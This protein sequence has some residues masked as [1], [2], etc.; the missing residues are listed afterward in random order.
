M[1][2]SCPRCPLLVA[3]LFETGGVNGWDWG[4]CL[5][6]LLLH[7]AAL[8]IQRLKRPNTDFLSGTRR[9]KLE[10]LVSP[11]GKG[12]IS[13]SQ[14]HQ[15]MRWQ[16]TLSTRENFHTGTCH[17]RPCNRPKDAFS[18]RLSYTAKFV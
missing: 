2:D 17:R 5:L 16:R 8:L 9:D 15:H 1:T 7:Q 12:E 10:T 11:R 6:L 18:F 13:H 14:H 3:I 4:L